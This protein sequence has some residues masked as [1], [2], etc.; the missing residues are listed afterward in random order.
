MGILLLVHDRAGIARWQFSV[1][2]RSP[3]WTRELSR[4]C[5]ARGR[6][7]AE[8]GEGVSCRVR[9]N[10]TQRYLILHRLIVRRH[11]ISPQHLFAWRKAARMVVDAAR[12]RGRDV[13]T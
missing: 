3:E 8:I 10:I 5:A 12:G 6:V 13:R 4:N 7:I 9:S 2:D 1:H 11:D